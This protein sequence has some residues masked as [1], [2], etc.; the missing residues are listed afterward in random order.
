MR[1]KTI[2]EFEKSGNPLK[3]LNV[4]IYNKVKA[5]L[6]ETYDNH[7]FL[8]YD[9]KD[10]NHIEVFYKTEVLNNLANPKKQE[11]IKWILKYIELPKYI[12]NDRK[13]TDTFYGK[14]FKEHKLTIYETEIL[15]NDFPKKYNVKYEQVFDIGDFN[16]E[17]I[18]ELGEIII[19]ALNENYEKVWGFELVE[20]IQ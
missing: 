16:K 15:F 18:N 3:N 10:L 9:I 5:K 11:K 6:D 7:M 4:G 2:F 17:G 8:T 12:L 1:A 13:S 14:E 20:Y 19:K